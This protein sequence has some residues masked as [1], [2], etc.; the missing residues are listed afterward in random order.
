MLNISLEGSH[1]GTEETKPINSNDNS[2]RHRS[3]RIT[4]RNRSPLMDLQQEMNEL[5]EESER[6]LR[7]SF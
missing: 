3:K 6:M 2:R 5:D 1:N 4:A 7:K